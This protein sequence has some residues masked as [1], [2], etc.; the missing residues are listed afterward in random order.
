MAEPV[1]I[2]QKLIALAMNNPNQEEARSAAVKAVALIVQENITLEGKSALGFDVGT[3]QKWKP[4]SE[5]EEFWEATKGN[6]HPDGAA[7]TW[8][9][10]SSG[11]QALKVAVQDTDLD[12]DF[13]RKRIKAAWRALQ[14]ERARLKSEIEYQYCQR[15]GAYPRPNP[16]D[17][18]K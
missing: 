12:D 13:M 9:G 15:F 8:D 2:I 7:E 14:R 18:E 5:F 10:Q 11:S 3:K 16:V 4:D 6:Q 17:W 1:A